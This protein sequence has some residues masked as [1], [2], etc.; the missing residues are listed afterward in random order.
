MTHP[1]HAILQQH[2]ASVVFG[3]GLSSLIINVVGCC[4]NQFVPFALTVLAVVL[5]ILGW[6]FGRHDLRAMREGSMDASGYA[7]TRSGKT[8][9]I[10]SVILA[11][12]VLVLQ[13][14][15]VLGIIAAI[16]LA[17]AAGAVGA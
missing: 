16:G 17:G 11:V 4:T 5:G 8:L 15:M 9:A 1:E 13:I 6:I 10:V 2:R 7:T 14:L 12:V 3:L